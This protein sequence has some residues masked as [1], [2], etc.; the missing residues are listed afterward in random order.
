MSTCAK[1]YEF[2]GR[3]GF[4]RFRRQAVNKGVI[5]RLW[6]SIRVLF[7]ARKKQK[8]Y[9]TELRKEKKFLVWKMA[10]YHRNSERK[11]I[12]QDY[13]RQEEE[14]VGSLC[15][16]GS[17]PVSPKSLLEQEKR[18]RREIANSNER[19][20][21]QSI[22][23]GFQS[24]RSLLP[25]REGEKLSKAAILQST[26]DYVY[27]LEQEKTRLLEQN[28]QLS[29]RMLN[30]PHINHDSD[31][32]CSDS[33]LPKRKK[34]D[35][36]DSVDE[37][38]GSSS[39]SRS[40][41][42]IEDVKR[43]MIDLRIQ[44]ERERTLRLLLEDQV[45]NLESQLYPSD[46]GPDSVERIHYQYHS[47]LEDNVKSA[48]NL[49]HE[50]GLGSPQ[51]QISSQDVES[52]HDISLRES[53][54]EL[55]ST[56]IPEDLSGKNNSMLL[57][58]VDELSFSDESPIPGLLLPASPVNVSSSF[59]DEINLTQQEAFKGSTSRQNL[60]T[61]VEAIRHVE[62]DHMFRDDS[63]DADLQPL[64]RMAV[65]QHY[66]EQIEHSV[67]LSNRSFSFQHQII[68]NAPL[69][70]PRPGV[71]VSNLS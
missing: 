15:R 50:S 25:Q 18:I 26:A 44:L 9:F 65:D 70:Q 61:I 43:E 30:S 29:R 6:I 38:I 48:M 34:R 41:N 35:L 71:I 55:S 37:G 22:N 46:N 28:N 68:R 40:E 60:E 54:P 2:F 66:T 33:P 13:R 62:G 52:N 64:H 36:A 14:V 5:E 39:P 12:P 42:G 20:R 1:E 63:A 27:Q 17:R 10:F 11:R 49:G 47:G 45:R 53:S 3:E 69:T 59:P 23:A 24:L 8:R 67:L 16:L 7:W 56:E 4:P 57:Q 21:M 58:C 31:G 32:S 19:R 51:S